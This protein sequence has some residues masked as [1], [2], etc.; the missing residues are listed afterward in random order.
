MKI[1]QIAP[2][3]EAVPPV[4]YGGTERVVANLCDALVDLG[5]E[6]VL[7]AAGNARTKARLVAVREQALRLDPDPLKSDLAA[8]LNLLDDVRK[9]AADFD[10][11]HFH[12]NLLHF[13]LAE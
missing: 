2:L 12:T 11:L 4:L 10:V 8:H 9:A 6:V 5:H 13:P 7:F 1:A 3:Y